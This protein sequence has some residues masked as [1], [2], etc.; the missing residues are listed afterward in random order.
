MIW[1]AASDRRFLDLPTGG[2]ESQ[3]AAI[4]RRTPNRGYGF[5]RMVGVAPIGVV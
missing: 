1:S 2:G 5:G 4:T 3:K